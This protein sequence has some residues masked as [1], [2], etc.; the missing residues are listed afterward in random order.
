MAKQGQLGTK[1]QDLVIEKKLET[2]QTPVQHAEFKYVGDDGGRWLFERRSDGLCFTIDKP[3][4]VP[5]TLQTKP[6]SVLLT[7]RGKHFNNDVLRIVRQ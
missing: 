3:K 1:E 2:P 6:L 5:L 7:V 4:N